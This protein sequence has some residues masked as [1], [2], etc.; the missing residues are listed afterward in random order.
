M[1]VSA[2]KSLSLTAFR[3]SS[4]TFTLA[5]EKGR[6]L[7]LVYGENG[8]GKTTICDGLEF[9]AEGNVGSLTAKGMGRALEKY[10]PSANKALCDIEI[11][12]EAKDGTS[13]VGR[14]IGK[15]PIFDPPNGRPRIALLR[16]QQITALIETAPAERYK[17]LQRFIDV[18][19]VEK[20]EGTLRKLVDELQ[21]DKD[22]A[23][24]AELQS[25]SALNDNFE[26]AGK[27]AGLKPVTWA[28]ALLA[29]PQENAAAELNAVGQL[30]SVM[31]AL[32]AYPD[33][34][35]QRQDALDATVQPLEDAEA[36][37]Q[38]AVVSVSAGAANTVKL[39]ELGKS[40]LHDHPE[41]EVCP[42]C[43]SDE[44]MPGLSESIEARLTQ[45]AAV[46][47][48]QVNLDKCKAALQK[49]KEGRAQLDENYKKSLDDYVTA[50]GSFEWGAHYT[51]PA[52]DPPEAIAEIKQ[53]LTGSENAAKTWADGEA[54]LRKGSERIAVVRSALSR[55]KSNSERKKLA[56]EL[57][58]K[59]KNALD[60]CVKARQSFT[61]RVMAEIA[62]QVGELY[63]KVHPNEG[64]DKIA[65]QLDPK[66]RASIEMQAKFAGKDV[67]PTAYF[68]QS[69]LDTLGLCVFLALALRD[70]PEE[71]ILILDDVL[72]SVDEPHVDRI[73][74]MLYGVSQQFRHTIITTH[75]RPWREKFRWGRLKPDQACQFVELT[76]WALD[77]GMRMK[78]ALP[79]TAR[80]KKLLDAE[81]PDLQAI[82]SKAGVMLEEA[83]DYL[84]QKYECSVPRRHGAAYTLGDLLPAVKGKLRDALLVEVVVPVE[85]AEPI[86]TPIALKPMLDALSLIAQ[87]RNVMGAHFNTLSFELLDADAMKFAK[88]VEQLAD[89]LVCPE[90]GWPNRDKSGSHWQN[91]GDTRR[92]HPLKKPS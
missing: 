1:T 55:Y 62:K 60:I 75:Y 51:F 68:S 48:A 24:A 67:P 69:H 90:H 72:G 54:A 66:K 71:K 9:L 15:Q 41:T 30:R 7:S 49:A 6:K 33:L 89:A 21:A 22:S 27:P 61:D 84:T 35:V 26:A 8:T 80:L 4:T 47:D 53:W 64:L 14:F 82:C 63:E 29:E 92:L 46:Q 83:L 50:K 34:L 73:I 32:A 78:S 18:E 10:W 2:L 77:G 81:D 57:V 16:Q 59:A 5:F 3:G 23:E 70:K 39:L 38:A 91:G 40:Y 20:S 43:E 76:G 11:I 25:Y 58:P 56:E 28:E 44:K 79:E 85:G 45:L 12:L 87:T 74:D 37:M 31:L 13:C 65:L 42:L 88:Q 86:V 19:N 52:S 17:V 36:T